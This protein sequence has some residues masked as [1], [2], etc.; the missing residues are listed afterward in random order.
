MNSLTINYSCGFCVD[1][2][3]K[4]HYKLSCLLNLPWINYI[5]LLQFVFCWQNFSISFNNWF[6]ELFGFFF[7]IKTSYL[8]HIP[9]QVNRIFFQI[10]ILV[11]SRQVLG[12]S[13]FDTINYLLLKLNEKSEFLP[14]CIEIL[15]KSERISIHFSR[16]SPKIDCISFYFACMCIES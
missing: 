1:S 15:A 10:V 11:I 14:S 3:P 12:I 6:I 16:L 5:K 13:F 7:L 9:K 4:Y 2:L 8:G